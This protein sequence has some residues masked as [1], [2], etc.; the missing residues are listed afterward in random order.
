MLELLTC[1][2]ASVDGLD[3]DVF[4]DLRTLDVLN[5]FVAGEI[6]NAAVLEQ[7]MPSFAPS[8]IRQSPG[9]CPSEM[10]ATLDPDDSL[11]LCRFDK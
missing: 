3:T 2:D 7:P 1:R 8:D 10:G 4:F 9:P 6:A 11:S 5:G